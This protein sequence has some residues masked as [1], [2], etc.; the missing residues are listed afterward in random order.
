MLYIVGGIVVFIVVIALFSFIFRLIKYAVVI[1]AVAVVIY[2]AVK[3]YYISVPIIVLCLLVAAFMYIKE[4]LSIIKWIRKKTEP[5]LEIEIDDV[6]SQSINQLKEVDENE[7]S[8]RFDKLVLPY[9]RANAFLNYFD[10]TIYTDEV[11]YFSIKKNA[12]KAELREFGT[13]V[14]R[15]G[16]YI[17][18]QSG[19]N[20]S[21]DY[22]FSF[23]NLYKIELMSEKILLDYVD[24]KE[25]KIIQKII[26]SADTT[27]NV[28][29][30]YQFF[31]LAVSHEF[32]HA[33]SKN[34]IITEVEYLNK[35]EEAKM[36]FSTEDTLR[37]MSTNLSNVSVGASTENYNA[38]YNEMKNFM[39]GSRGNGYAAEYGNNVLDK[40]QG[41]KVINAA[42]NLD[43]NGRQIKAGADRIVNGQEIQTKYYKTASETIGAAFEKKQA[44]YLKN[45][46]SGKMMQIEVPRD[47]YQKALELMQKRIDSNQVPNLAPGEDARNYVRKGYFTYAQSFNI[48]KSGSLES[49][50]IDVI[51]GAICTSVAGGF[52]AAIV[53]ATAIW[54]GQST[55]EAAKISV[56]AGMKTMGKGTIIYTLTMQLSREQFI[57]PFVKEVVGNGI[58][59]GFGGVGNPIF[60]ASENLAQKISTSSLAKTSIGEAIGLPTLKGKM[61][62]SSSITAIIVFGPDVCLALRGRISSKQLLKNS[63]VGLA[64]ILGIILGQVLV[65]IPLL[66]PLIGGAASSFVVKKTLDKFIEDDSV[67]MFQILKEEFL[68]AIMLSHLT[69]NEFN[70]VTDATLGNKKLNELLRGMYASDNYRKFAKE[71]IMSAAISNVIYKRKKITNSMMTLGYKE[72]FIEMEPTSEKQLVY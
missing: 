26:S 46:G 30:L 35:I 62:L 60:I 16:I 41:K 56:Y 49:I 42:Q 54:N 24:V 65:P 43:S 1:G 44:V 29:V 36:A 7:E 71:A 4:K 14:T 28:G 67:L 64:G 37:H 45:D 63:S 61:L 13:M 18:K 8:Y 47:Q 58:Y 34:R 55:K 19:E 23:A 72:L 31:E 11:Y 17:S 2:L 57:N 39:N 69:Q 27:I 68:E 48:A 32:N 5:V 21:D 3:F 70:E 9:G 25:K 59:K 33:L 15:R 38:E 51:N 20:T 52:T 53:F 50:T 10:K 40:V 6:F 22:N 12:Y 66:G